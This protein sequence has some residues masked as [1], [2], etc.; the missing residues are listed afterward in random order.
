MNFADY[1]ILA[2]NFTVMAGIGI[3]VAS[4]LGLR[5]S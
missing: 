3:W 5:K 4:I 2:L 1:L